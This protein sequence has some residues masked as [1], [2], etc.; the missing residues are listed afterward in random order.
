MQQQTSD[1]TFTR[2]NLGVNV[3]LNSTWPMTV[4]SG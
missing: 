1:R 2:I 3:A 4:N